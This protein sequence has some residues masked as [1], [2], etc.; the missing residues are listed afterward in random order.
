MDKIKN[1]VLQADFKK[2]ARRFTIAV[3]ALALIS[4]IA[5]G[6]LL[7]NQIKDIYN[8]AQQEEHQITES[9]P[10]AKQ[11]TAISETNPNQLQNT[12]H[13]SSYHA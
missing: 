13:T 6:V 10:S 5:G 9:I 3:I 4:G 12:K 8:L 11:R 1:K 2:I 7:Q